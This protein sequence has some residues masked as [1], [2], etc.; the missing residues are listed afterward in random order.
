[1]FVKIRGDMKILILLFLI[2]SITMMGCI[3]DSECFLFNIDENVA[4]SIIKAAS[5]INPKER[6]KLMR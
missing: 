2:I 1:L 6:K 3:P 4:M 5:S